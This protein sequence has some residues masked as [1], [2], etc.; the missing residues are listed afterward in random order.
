MTSKSD[1]ADLRRI[2]AI[3]DECTEIIRQ[4][5]DFLFREFSS[6]L[7]AFYRVAAKSFGGD[8]YVGNPASVAL[9][10]EKYLRH[11][12]VLMGGR[13]DAEYDASIADIYRLRNDFGVDFRLSTAG[14][15]FIFAQVLEAIALRLPRK[16]FEIFSARRRT[17]VQLAYFRISMLDI[18]MT[19]DSYL[20]PARTSGCALSI[21]WQILR[22]CDRRYRFWR[23]DCG[24][25]FA[26][27][28]GRVDPIGGSDQRTIHGGRTGLARG[29]D[30]CSS[31]R[32]RD[33]LSVAGDRRSQRPRP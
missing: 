2:Y 6:A 16:P 5:F 19:M 24:R 10:R 8:S 28:G 21:I 15:S 7:D 26:Q 20:R 4:N 25:G 17:K 1:V 12:R 3:D 22:T 32:Q 23:D 31:R 30:E 33:A 18:V 14:R 13:F 27:Y 29:G 11:W 9:A